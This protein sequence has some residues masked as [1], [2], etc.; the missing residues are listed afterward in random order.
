MEGHRSSKPICVGS[1]PTTPAL[2]SVALT[3][4]APVLHTGGCGFKAHRST[5][6]VGVS[7]PLG[8]AEVVEAL[9]CDT[10]V[11]EFSSRRS[12]QP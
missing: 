12:S 7:A 10:S 8:L 1:I 2:G 9:V 3:G 4:R 6:T 5:V 11:S